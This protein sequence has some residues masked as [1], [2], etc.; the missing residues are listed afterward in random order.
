MRPQA[1]GASV[2]QPGGLPHQTAR[3]FNF[4][5]HVRQHKL[6]RLKLANRFAK[7]APLLRVAHGRFECALGDAHG[8]RGNPHAPAVERLERDLQPL[9]FL[10]Q[11]V[12]DWDLAIGQRDFRGARTAQAHFILVA[13]DAKAGEAWFHQKSRHSARA[14]LRIGLGKNDIEAAL[15]AAGDPGLHAVEPVDVPVAHRARLQRR[16]IRSRLRFR[17]A[18][19]AENFAS[20][21]L[22]QVFPALRFRAV[23]G[24]AAKRPPNWSRS[25]PPPSRHRH[26]PLLPASERRRSNPR[27]RRPTPRGSTCRSSP[28]HPIAATRRRRIFLRGHFGA[29]LGELPPP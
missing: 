16:R 4:R 2:P 27:P 5:L 21:K 10:A 23:P 14:G 7:C 25:A 11:A 13:A 8:L 6:N 24:T 26:A 9:P 12:L 18:K 19:A 22:R 29:R 1:R 17:K 20:R 28:A 3:R 15:P